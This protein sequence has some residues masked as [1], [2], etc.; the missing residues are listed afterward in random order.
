MPKV[1]TLC[2]EHNEGGKGRKQKFQGTYDDVSAT[3]RTNLDPTDTGL[4]GLTF[5][6]GSFAGVEDFVVCHISGPDSDKAD[7]TRQEWALQAIRQDNGSDF[8]RLLC[9][10]LPLQLGK[11][12]K[13][14]LVPG[15]EWAPAK[16]LSFCLQVMDMDMSNMQSNMQSNKRKLE[17][18]EEKEEAKEKEGEK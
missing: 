13:L 4:S 8:Q 2:V 9:A 15:E 18:V 5:E 16:G 14:P 6:I 10:R 17:A 11:V 7:Q 12:Y 1:F 3:I